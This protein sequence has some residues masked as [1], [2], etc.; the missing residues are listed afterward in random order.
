MLVVIYLIFAVI[1][2]LKHELVAVYRT[3]IILVFN[4]Y[5]LSLYPS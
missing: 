1:N 4:K 3:R 2:Y 5:L